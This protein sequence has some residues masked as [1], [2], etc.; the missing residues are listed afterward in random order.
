MPESGA[1]ARKRAARHGSQSGGLFETRFK[2]NLII[3]QFLMVIL[4]TCVC[5]AEIN[6]KRARARVG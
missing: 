2:A 6:F 5:T 1:A 4:A 3:F